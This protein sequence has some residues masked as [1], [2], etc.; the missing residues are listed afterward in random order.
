MLYPNLTLVLSSRISFLWINLHDYDFYNCSGFYS[1]D[2]TFGIYNLDQ[3]RESF[4]KEILGKIAKAFHH[5]VDTNEATARNYINPIIVEAV[6]AVQETHASVRL[7]VEEESDGS[8]GY[9]WFDYAIHLEK[10]AV[11]VTEAKVVEINNGIAKN[12]A[13][14]HTAVEV[15]K[16]SFFFEFVYIFSLYLTICLYFYPGK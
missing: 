12:L 8:K 11:V 13:Q 5:Q 3:Q 7:E 6:S 1:V 4:L 10:L 2:N 14:L 16:F 9:G 15:P